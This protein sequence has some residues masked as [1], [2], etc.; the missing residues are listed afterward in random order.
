MVNS[1][2]SRN[3]E[4]VNELD[5]IR[6]QRDLYAGKLSQ[7]YKSRGWKLLNFSRYRS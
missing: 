6:K 7:I 3:R 1:H 4:I 5:E 2:N